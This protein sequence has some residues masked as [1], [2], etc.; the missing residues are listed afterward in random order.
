MQLLPV[1]AW[2]PYG[3]LRDCIRPRTCTTKARRV[4]KMILKR[5]I[6]LVFAGALAFSA[7]A[8]EIVVRIAP[9][10]MGIQRRGPRPGPKHV[11]VQGY[12]NWDGNHYVWTQ[13]RW[14]QPPRAR[15]HWVAH[16]WV[17]RNGGYVLVEGH[18]S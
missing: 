15:A 8:G 3:G 14:E 6:G 11:W 18:W 5:V 4:A 7:M 10:R 17:R 9:P 2:P 1:P 13:G 12:H 16:H